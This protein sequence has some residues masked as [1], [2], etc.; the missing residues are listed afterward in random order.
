MSNYGRNY[1]NSR[2]DNVKSDFEH[3]NHTKNLST[4]TR[5]DVLMKMCNKEMDYYGDILRAE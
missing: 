1:F 4:E 5:R 2:Y 3:M